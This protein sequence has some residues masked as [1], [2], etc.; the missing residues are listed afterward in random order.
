MR[1]M[2]TVQAD[3]A[4]DEMAMRD[5]MAALDSEL[6]S[7]FAFEAHGLEDSR[8][9]NEALWDMMKDDDGCV[10][11][12]IDSDAVS[13]NL[14]KEMVNLTQYHSASILH[15][16]EDLEET[17]DG[18]RPLV[19]VCYWRD[20]VVSFL[21]AK[22]LDTDVPGGAFKF[23]VSPFAERE[24]MEISQDAQLLCNAFH[25]REPRQAQAAAPTP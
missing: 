20:G 12:D 18:V 23:L 2:I 14:G 10:R 24:F 22:T 13:S 17:P 9:H 16:Y 25:A 4:K 3:S 11:L 15:F 1:V 7:S 5:F 8:D 19:G 21:D 6:L